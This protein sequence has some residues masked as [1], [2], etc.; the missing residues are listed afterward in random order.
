MKLFLSK[1]AVR[2]F[3]TLIGLLTFVGFFTNHFKNKHDAFYVKL[4][5]K[6]D[7]GL[8]IGDS[9]ALQG[10]NPEYLSFPT[11]NFAFT[12]GHSPFDNSYL[13]LIQKKIDTNS[14]IKRHH[15]IS[16]TP[17][18]LLSP[19][20]VI[21]DIN[22]YFSENLTLQFTNP[23]WEYILKYWDLS[24]VNSLKLLRNKSFTTDLGWNNQ[25][26]DSTE[27]YREYPRRVK[28][29]IE[30]YKHK[31]NKQNLTIESH[32]VKN[33]LNIIQYMKKTGK[34]TIVRLPVSAEML[35]LE[36]E[37]F[38]NFENLCLEISNKYAVKFIDLTDFKIQTTDGNHIWGFEVPKIM[39][40]L[41]SRIHGVSKL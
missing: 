19:E 3:I 36:K 7:K 29:K 30:N 22:P 32:R 34:V 23:N 25:N 14:K 17:W 41:E 18:S 8:I 4:L 11:F 16:I 33:L 13:K 9:R 37:R 12:I 5:D 2:L 27:L 39:K 40:E 24:I 38:A 20:K 28:E 6:T 1:I 26:I 15:I 35:K 31:Y 10:I 21:E